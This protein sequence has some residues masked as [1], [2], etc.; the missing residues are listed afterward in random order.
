MQM[1]AFVPVVEDLVSKVE[2]GRALQVRVFPMLW[3]KAQR[4][5]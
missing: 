2:K 3:E 1:L 5:V 4:N